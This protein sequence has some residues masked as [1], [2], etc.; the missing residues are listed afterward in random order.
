MPD[1]PEGLGERISRLRR[2]RRWTQRELAKRAGARAAQ[3]SRY[4]RGGHEPRLDVLSRIAR[5]LDTTTDF[6]ITG[7]EPAGDA[8]F[9]T[10]VP[11]LEALPAVLRDGLAELLEGLLRSYQVVQPGSGAWKRQKART[12][13]A[14]KA[15][16]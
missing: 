7:S 15:P 8:R 13:Q 6:L 1:P 3:I 16:E 14:A 11:R 9:R 5:A 4:E 2:R 12:A 10:L